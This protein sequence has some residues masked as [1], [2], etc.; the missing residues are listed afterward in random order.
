MASRSPRA[1]GE[2]GSESDTEKYPARQNSGDETGQDGGGGGGGGG[3]ESDNDYISQE[4]R[5][6]IMETERLLTES[7]AGGR[8]PEPGGAGAVRR[9]S[10]PQHSR[11]RRKLPQIPKDKKRNWQSHS[12]SLWLLLTVFSFS[13]RRSVG[14]DIRGALSRNTELG[15]AE[16]TGGR[17]RG[18][19]AG[20]PGGG[21]G[22]GG[23]FHCLELRQINSGGLS[24]SSSLSD[25]QRCEL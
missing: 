6:R 18:E 9:Q 3:S 8:L 22:G 13:F 4:D 20:R 19:G 11:R 15:G 14:L 5:Q 24:S 1:T 25:P 16:V 17:E 12:E 2:T 7:E 21:G 23:S 10:G